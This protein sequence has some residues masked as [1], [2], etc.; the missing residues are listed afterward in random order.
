MECSFI[1]TTTIK[2]QQCFSSC[3]DSLMDTS[4]TCD[5]LPLSLLQVLMFISMAFVII[6]ILETILESHFLFR[7]VYNEDSSEPTYTRAPDPEPFYNPQPPLFTPCNCYCDTNQTYTNY[8]SD[9]NEP[10]DYP[11]TEPHP[12]LSILD[13][14]CLV[15]LSYFRQTIF[16]APKIFG[17]YGLF[18]STV[19]NYQELNMWNSNKIWCLGDRQI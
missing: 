17:V 16:F 15:S 7:V 1:K 13:D 14:V 19:W 11:H 2:D 4:F 6:S 12:F 9:I 10:E 18:Y 5:F 8:S 3:L